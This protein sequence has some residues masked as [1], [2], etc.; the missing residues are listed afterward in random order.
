MMTKTEL[1]SRLD[2]VMNKYTNQIEAKF[3]EKFSNMEAQLKN[4]EAQLKDYY[5][6]TDLRYN[7]IIGL[8]ITAAVSIIGIVVKLH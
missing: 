6:K 1:D 7:W 2:A 3:D 4:M 5:H 8:V